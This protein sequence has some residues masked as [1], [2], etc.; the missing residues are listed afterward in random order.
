MRGCTCATSELERSVQR[1]VTMRLGGYHQLYIDP[2]IGHRAAASS[3]LRPGW[4]G[5]VRSGAGHRFTGASRSA[6]TVE[7]SPS[8]NSTRGVHPVTP[9]NRDASTTMSRRSPGVASAG[10]VI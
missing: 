7:A 5:M 1:V 2:R 10:G 3:G 4:S 9:W 8:R 6:A